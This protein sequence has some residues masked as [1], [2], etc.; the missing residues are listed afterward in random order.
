MRQRLFKLLP[1]RFQAVVFERIARLMRRQMEEAALLMQRRA[2]LLRAKGPGNGD[3]E[4]QDAYNGLRQVVHDI[5]VIIGIESRR[6]MG[7]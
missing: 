7:L 5:T 4:W 6:A 3:A 2:Q 1:P